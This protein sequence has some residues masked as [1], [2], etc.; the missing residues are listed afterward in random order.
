MYLFGG[1]GFGDKKPKPLV[2]L[3]L[4][5]ENEKNIPRYTSTHR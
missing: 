1:N 5:G 2:F 3:D 4:L